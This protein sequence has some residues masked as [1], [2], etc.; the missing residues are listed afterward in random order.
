[1][2]RLAYRKFGAAAIDAA[3]FYGNHVQAPAVALQSVVIQRVRSLMTSVTP[4]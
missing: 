4:A 3:T 2:S 1:M